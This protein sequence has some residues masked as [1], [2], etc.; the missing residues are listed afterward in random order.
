MLRRQLQRSARRIAL[1]AFVMAAGLASAFYILSQERLQSPFASSYTVYAAFSGLA[2]VAPGLGEPV[3]VS[4]VQVGQIGG[5]KLADGHG[6]LE[7]KIDPHKL[8]RV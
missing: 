2:G 7:L 8:P 4:G 6:V 1:I 5:A 3:N